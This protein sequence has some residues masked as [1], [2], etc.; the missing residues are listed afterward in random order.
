VA[1]TCAVERVAQAVWSSGMILAQGARGPGFN[2]QNSPYPTGVEG[3]APSHGSAPAPRQYVAA[4]RNY[5]RRP[6]RSAQG[7]ARRILNENTHRG[8]RTHDHKVK[9]LALYRL[10]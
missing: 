8:A 4:P 10:S 2:S 5:A 1:V 9:G 7:E 6:G 3:G